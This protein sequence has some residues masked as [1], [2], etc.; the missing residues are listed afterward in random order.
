[1]EPVGPGWGGG[2]SKGPA[3]THLNEN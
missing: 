2:R 3:S 1:M